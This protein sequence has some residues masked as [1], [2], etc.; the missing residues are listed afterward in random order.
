MVA[1][2][3]IG[4]ATVVRENKIMRSNGS[5]RTVVTAQLYNC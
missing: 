5:R 3:K 2:I 1:Y 4:K